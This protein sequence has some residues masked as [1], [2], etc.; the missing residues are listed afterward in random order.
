M[1]SVESTNSEFK[2]EF[3]EPI[4]P[5]N[6]RMLW[7]VNL[8]KNEININNQVFKNEWNNLNYN[9]KLWEF[10]GSDWYYI[11]I[12]G[13]S[14]II[15]KNTFQIFYLKYQNVSTA[16][17]KG[18][19]IEKDK[20]IEV[21]TNSISITNMTTR[22]NIEVDWELKGVLKSINLINDNEIEIRY[23]DLDIE[24]LRLLSNQSLE[25]IE[26]NIEFEDEEIG[27]VKN[28]LKSI[29]PIISIQ[30]IDENLINNLY[31]WFL[32]TS[33][34]DDYLGQKG[35]IIGNKMLSKI[36]NIKFG[37]KEIVNY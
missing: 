14:A 15:H 19:K 5:N 3:I 16:R 8:W 31:T 30:S 37:K 17:F 6:G 18:N 7:K 13:E 4:E 32:P 1:K 33:I 24:E 12:E 23:E 28:A 26:N 10:E 22:E 11:P 27:K 9:L 2:I 21:Y 29:E 25:A 35:E 20:I 34:W 36:E